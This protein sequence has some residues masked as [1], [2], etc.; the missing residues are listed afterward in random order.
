MLEEWG[1][2]VIISPEGEAPPRAVIL[3]TPHLKLSGIKGAMYDGE[4]VKTMLGLM[5]N[6]NAHAGFYALQWSLLIH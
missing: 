1:V 6:Q 2:S 5:K 3:G 4:K